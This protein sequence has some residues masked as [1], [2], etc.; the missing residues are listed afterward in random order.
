[1]KKLPIILAALL[2]LSGCSMHTRYTLDLKLAGFLGELA[3]G[4]VEL[5]AYQ[6]FEVYLPDDQDGDLTTPDPDGAPVQI[7][8]LAG[9]LERIRIQ[10]RATIEETGGQPLAL[11]A[12]IYVGG[13][14]AADLYHGDGV[15]LGEASLRLAAGESGTLDLE[16][17]LQEGD[18]GYDR[19]AGGEF[20]LG[21][22]LSGSARAFEYAIEHLE[23]RLTTPPLGEL[24]R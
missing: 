22:K 11:S 16:I 14:D 7:P 15:K 21:L 4:S 9:K 8:A 24:L 13:I 10:L 18:P 19:I 5:P 23:L 12:A 20:R 17:S 3:R 1:M 2:L 6:S